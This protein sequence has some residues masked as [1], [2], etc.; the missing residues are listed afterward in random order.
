MWLGCNKKIVKLKAR[1]TK[2]VRF[3]LSFAANGVFEIG[4]LS[5]ETIMKMNLMDATSLTS[6]DDLIDNINSSAFNTSNVSNS[7]AA[8]E[9]SSLI[10]VYL[11]SNKT[12]GDN[13]ELFKRLNPFTVCILKQ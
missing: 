11:K 7:T 5:N 2:Q 12:S 4:Q 9:T 8:N 1:Q 10:S 6:F 13:Y 3:R